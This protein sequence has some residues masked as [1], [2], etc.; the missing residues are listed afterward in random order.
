[1]FC[2]QLYQ[3]TT[4]AYGGLDANNPRSPTSNPT[5]EYVQE[6]REK[7]EDDYKNYWKTDHRD[8]YDKED[9]SHLKNAPNQTTAV[10]GDSK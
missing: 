6:I 1:V 10:K 3:L 8:W 4:K 9:N 2:F 5:T 7:A